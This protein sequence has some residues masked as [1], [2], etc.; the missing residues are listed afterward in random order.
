MGS[1]LRPWIGTTSRIATQVGGRGRPPCPFPIAIISFDRPSLLRLTL[2][3]LRNQSF[4]INDRQVHLFQDGPVFATPEAVDLSRQCIEIFK[5]I[6]PY[7]QVHECLDNIGVAR[8]FDRAERALFEDLKADCGLFFEDDLILA[9]NYLLVL[10]RLAEFALGEPLVG[11][12][13]AYGVHTA[14]LEE[15]RAR[16]AE[17]VPLG[18]N[19]GFALTR[20]QW[21]RQRE[22][23]QNYL[24]LLRDQNY[25]QRPHDRIRAYFRSLGHPVVPTS[26]DAAKAVACLVT[27]VARINCFPCFARYVGESGL[28]MRPAMFEE[29]GFAKTVLY[30]GPVPE[31]RFPKRAELANLVQTA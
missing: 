17:I 10:I 30:D 4:A 25:R 5:G 19:W 20:T 18:H 26:Q 24:D 16:A 9:P 11:Y 12:V 28:H 31:F 29:M 23:V 1:I 2:E 8:N 13:A 15:Q 27:G 7:G 22:L 3:S 14:S 21:E 6:F